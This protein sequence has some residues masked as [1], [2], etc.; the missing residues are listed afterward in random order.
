[1]SGIC[2][3]AARSAGSFAA[4][5]IRNTAARRSSV[6]RGLPSSATGGRRRRRCA[7]RIAATYRFAASDF[8]QRVERG[9]RS[10]ASREP[11]FDDCFHLSGPGIAESWNGQSAGRGVSRGACRLRRSGRSLCRRGSGSTRLSSLCF[12][13]PD[14]QLMLTEHTQPAILT[15][16]V[17]A[18]R[19]LAAH[20]I[21]AGPGRGPQPWRVLS[22]RRRRR[23]S[24][25]P[26]PCRWFA[27]GVATCRRPCRSVHGAMAAILGLDAER[28]QTR[29]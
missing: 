20:G 10:A 13:G 22:K 3:P 23:A 16:S 9:N 21:A 29:V 11:K 26:M 7:T 5:T 27:G 18:A 8:L 19:V 12:E 15:V 28:R 4:S 14:D 17:A 2:C 1:M 24:T 25:S 6:S